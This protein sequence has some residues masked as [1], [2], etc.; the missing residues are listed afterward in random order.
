MILDGLV[1]DRRTP[2]HP[3]NPAKSTVRL[4][5]GDRFVA[6][7][8]VYARGGDLLLGTRLVV[9]LLPGNAK[10]ASEL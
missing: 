6:D 3:A 7:I 2:G 5:Q 4:F 8:K 1:I 9:N 10:T